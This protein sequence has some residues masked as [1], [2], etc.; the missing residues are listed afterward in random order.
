MAG[1]IIMFD[2]LVGFGLPLAF[3]IWQLRSVNR[4]LDRDR[5]KAESGEPA[6]AES[7]TS[8]HI[9]FQALTRN[10]SR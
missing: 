3:A 7:N 5:R 6:D 8:E 1:A 9:V 10:A 4:E 2:A